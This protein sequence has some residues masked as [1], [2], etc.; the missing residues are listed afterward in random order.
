MLFRSAGAGA[1]AAGLASLAQFTGSNL[2]RQMDE[3]KRLGQTELGYAAAAAVPQ[4]ALDMVSFKMA[5]GIRQIFAAAGKDVPE[6]M[7]EQIAKQ[8]TLQIAKDYGLSVGKAMGAE[9]ITEAGQQFFE[10]LQAGL[11][12]TDAKAREEYWDSLVGGA[13]LGG[14]LAPAGRYVERDRKSTRLNSSHMS[15]SRM[16]SS[17]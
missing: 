6:K 2:S 13:V 15:E 16:P 1:A 5:P 7:A 3:G 10:R 12:L 8:G 14:A 17:A 11:N 4:A 9:G